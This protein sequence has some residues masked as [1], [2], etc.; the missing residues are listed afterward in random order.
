MEKRRFG[1]GMKKL[2][3]SQA[4]ILVSAAAIALVLVTILFDFISIN[5]EKVTLLIA[6]FAVI[7]ALI[8]AWAS[9]QTVKLA[10]SNILPDVVLIVDVMSRYSIIQ[11]RMTNLG[12]SPAFNI[13][14]KWNK[15]LR[16]QQGKIISFN[17]TDT[18]NGIKI[19]HAKESIAQFIDSP[20]TLFK[21][22]Q[23]N[24]NLEE[25]TYSGKINFEDSNGSKYSKPFILDFAQYKSS[26]LFDNEEIATHHELQKIPEKLK[27][28]EQA[29]A[30]LSK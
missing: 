27:G 10:Q 18:Y 3:F 20:M 28:I 15:E 2:S 13:E 1:V 5:Q 9:E 23:S 8:S 17:K 6:S 7:S 12:G 22:Y 21:K 29:I 25:L 4:I 30:G 11:V 19:L 26:L 14:V 16:N 24:E